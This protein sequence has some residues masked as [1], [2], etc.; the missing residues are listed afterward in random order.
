MGYIATHH[1][2]PP[3]SFWLL[4]SGRMYVAAFCNITYSSCCHANQL[5]LHLC[6]IRTTCSSH[7]LR[8][9][10]IRCLPP[11]SSWAVMAPM[12][13]YSIFRSRLEFSFGYEHRFLAKTQGFKGSEASELIEH[14]RSALRVKS[15]PLPTKIQG[16]N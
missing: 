13:L 9:L 3:K 7:T 11:K 14:R 12:L 10:V 2:E 6:G 15:S 16:F 1:V 5:I 4:A 8:V